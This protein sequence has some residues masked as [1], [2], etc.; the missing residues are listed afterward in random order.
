M[1]GCQGGGKTELV[2][3]R[4]TPFAREKGEVFEMG[5]NERRFNGARRE[6]KETELREVRNVGNA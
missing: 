6:S 1:G 3:S 2:V 5:E 4:Q